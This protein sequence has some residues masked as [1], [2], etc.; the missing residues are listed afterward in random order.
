MLVLATLGSVYSPRVAISVMLRIKWSESVPISSELSD[1]SRAAAITSVLTVSDHFREKHQHV[2]LK[3]NSFVW[4]DG[5]SVQFCSQ[6]VFKLLSSTDS[7]LNITCCYNERHHGKGPMDGIG[8]TL[9]YCVYQD[10]MS[11][12]SVIETPKPLRNIP[13]KKSKV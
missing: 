10:E 13:P 5:C 4:S 12:K 7:S 2:P 11:G 9:K 6:F 1:L 8:G 3:N